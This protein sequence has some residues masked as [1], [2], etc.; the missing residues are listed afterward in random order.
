MCNFDVSPGWRRALITGGRGRCGCRGAC[1][2]LDELR[3]VRAQL[4]QH[5]HLFLRRRL[6][7][8]AEDAVA[9]VWISSWKCVNRARIDSE[10]VS[11]WMKFKSSIFFAAAC[12]KCESL[13][14]LSHVFAAEA[15][16]SFTPSVRAS[17][18]KSMYRVCI[19]TRV[20]EC[21][22]TR[23]VQCEL[24]VCI[25]NQQRQDPAGLLCIHRSEVCVFSVCAHVCVCVC[26]C[27]SLPLAQSSGQQQAQHPLGP[28]LP[29]IHPG[30]HNA[31]VF[32][33]STSQE[34]LL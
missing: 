11:Q 12:C 13:S 20:Y 28:P 32:Q 15:L 10:A 5:F 3:M 16:G 18:C 24:Y 21:I 25:P 7:A 9:V 34:T 31:S 26:A 33:S 8:A 23:I 4:Q 17:V 29:T 2:G 14:S 6:R 27:T 19:K 1:W 22:R 30:S